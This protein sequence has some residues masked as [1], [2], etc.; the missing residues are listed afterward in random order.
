MIR[1]NKSKQCKIKKTACYR[2][3]LEVKHS[4]N[5]TS[6]KGKHENERKGGRKKDKRETK[7]EQERGKR[8]RQR[9]KLSKELIQ[10]YFPEL[11]A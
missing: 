5:R 3:H 2:F 9:E 8:E 4:M 11:R 1:K 7:E 6:R 10:E